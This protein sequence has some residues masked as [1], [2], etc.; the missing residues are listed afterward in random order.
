MMCIICIKRD[1]EETTPRR[2]NRFRSERLFGG[3]FTARA[4][5]EVDDCY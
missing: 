1:V 2:L 5:I 3:E 4:E